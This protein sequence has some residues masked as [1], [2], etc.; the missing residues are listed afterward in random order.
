MSNE[1]VFDVNNACFDS[2][3]DLNTQDWYVFS[4]HVE[5]GY[6]DIR[7]QENTNQPILYPRVIYTL[8]FK[9]TGLRKVALIIMP[10]MLLLFLASTSALPILET[11]TLG[12]AIGCVTGM[13][14]YRYV[15]NSISPNVGYFTLAEHIY[16]IA[17]GLVFFT[18]ALTLNKSFIKYSPFGMDLGI[19]W[20]ILIKIIMLSS[21]Y[22][23]LFRWKRSF[24]RASLCYIEHSR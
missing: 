10:I 21:L 23:L 24:E 5:S 8:D 15:I 13:L 1:V 11:S 22:Y 14:G 12:I 18:F 3:D 7:L 17:L 19:L 6:V 4:K 20:F 9:K 2:S 16:N